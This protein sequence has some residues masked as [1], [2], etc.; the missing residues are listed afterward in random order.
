M[1]QLVLTQIPN[2]HSAKPSKGIQRRAA[3]VLA[4]EV[5]QMMHLD[6]DSAG[7][8]MRSLSALLLCAAVAACGTTSGRATTVQESNPSVTYDYSDDEGLVDATIKAEAY[9]SQFNAWPT[10]AGAQMTADGKGTVTFRCDQ[11]RTA[12]Y[13]G[14]QPPPLPAD[15]TVN[16]SYTHDEDLI[17]ATVRAQRHCARFGAEARSSTVTSGVDGDRTIV[18]ECVPASTR[19]Y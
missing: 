8:V 18:F 6:T 16:Y 14:S 5:M 1:A 15:P 11:T 9:C 13:S 12:A 17:E 3:L 19:R 7:R 2:L 10:T 4:E